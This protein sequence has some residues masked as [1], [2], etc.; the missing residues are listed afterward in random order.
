MRAARGEAIKKRLSLVAQNFQ[1]ATLIQLH[2]APTPSSIESTKL[3]KFF[4]LAN[5]LSSSL[6]RARQQEADMP[7]AQL[8]QLDDISIKNEH[9][10]LI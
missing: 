5:L 6:T 9:T 8:I 4:P 10:T 3:I 2:Q 1:L 7:L